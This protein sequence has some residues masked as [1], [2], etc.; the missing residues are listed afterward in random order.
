MANRTLSL[1]KKLLNFAC[2]QGLLESNPAARVKPPGIET[3]RDR[4]LSENELRT[5]WHR[6]TDLSPTMR[7]ACRFILLTA[8][9]SGEVLSAQWHEVENDEWVI[10]GSKT[11]NGLSHRVPLS[12]QALRVLPPRST[13]RIFPVTPRSLSRAIQRCRTRWGIEHFTPHD[14]RRSAA[15]HMARLGINRLVISKILNHTNAS[16]TSIYDRHSYQPEMREALRK[17]GDALEEIVG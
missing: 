13:G 1:T 10:P 9:R 14:L 16:V 12:P 7:A 6:L 8:A 4:V 3:P 11:K 15:S 2:D 5:L 17:W